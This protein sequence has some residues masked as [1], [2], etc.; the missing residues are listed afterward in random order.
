MSLRNTSTHWGL[1]ARL[2][3]GLFF[4]LILGAW[5]AVDLHEDFPKGS[6]E[7]AQWMLLHKSLGATVFFLVWVRLFWRLGGD[8]PA[9]LPAP[10]W[11]QWSSAAV[12]GALY[13]VMIAMPLSGLLW[14]QFGDRPV[15]WFGLFEIPV[16]LTPDKALAGQLGA[17]HKEV[18][19]PLLLTLIA[20]HAAAA[21]WHHFVLK[22]ATLK[23][24]FFPRRTS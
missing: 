11:Q 2:L 9:P 10:R 8:V 13:L 18:L 22:D 21:L 17:L 5:I 12:H 23:R 15:S 3:H 20:V 19:W 1:V 16:F 14:S 7:R 6:A 4:L 24:M